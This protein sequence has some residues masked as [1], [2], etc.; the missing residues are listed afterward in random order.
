MNKPPK[1]IQERRTP[2][3]KKKQQEPPKRN[4]LRGLLKSPW[5]FLVV[6]ATV[7][8]AWTLIPRLSV[9]TNGSLRASDPFGTVF[10]LSNDGLFPIRHVSALCRLDTFTIVDTGSTMA[11]TSLGTP[12]AINM[13]ILSPSKKLTLPCSHSIIHGYKHFKGDMTIEVSYQPEFL[14][15]KTSLQQFPFHLNSRRRNFYV[16]TQA[17]LG[18]HP[19]IP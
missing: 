9:S 18:Q 12:E 11:G 5:T 17:K 10:V 1:Y 7:A 3:P 14:P 19:S 2:T 8:S 15:F 13:E 4:V 16:D 6:L